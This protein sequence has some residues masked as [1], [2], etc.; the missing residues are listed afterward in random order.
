MKME[1]LLNKLKSEYHFNLVEEDK[2]CNYWIFERRVEGDTETHMVTLE[3]HRWEKEEPTYKNYL[4][5][6]LDIGDWLIISESKDS[7]IDWYG[8][9]ISESYPLTLGETMLFIEIIKELE[10]K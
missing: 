6:G 3:D 7:T 4:D 8:S 2:M 9:K 1:E 5:G 10:K